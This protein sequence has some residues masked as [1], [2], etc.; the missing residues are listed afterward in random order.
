M[1]R[2]ANSPSQQAKILNHVQPVNPVNFDEE[3]N[4]D[5]Q[6]QEE[7]KFESNLI[8][9][10]IDADTQPQSVRPVPRDDSSSLRIEGASC[11]VSNYDEFERNRLN[12]GPVEQIQPRNGNRLE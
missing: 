4:Q 10:D 2:K 9:F 1:C 6:G 8:V 3:I 11:S 5:V 12:E 7:E